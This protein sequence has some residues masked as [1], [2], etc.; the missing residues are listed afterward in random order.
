MLHSDKKS[1]SLHRT[2][3]AAATH[4]S[5]P[6]DMLAVKELVQTL[7]T[8]WVSCGLHIWSMQ[9]EELYVEKHAGPDAGIA[10]DTLG[11]SGI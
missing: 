8:S 3:S 4:S 2:T 1:L 10:Q 9:L 6:P 5:V 7:S 11:P